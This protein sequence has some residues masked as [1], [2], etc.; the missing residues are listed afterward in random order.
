MLNRT[1]ESAKKYGDKVKKV[2]ASDTE[3]LIF[4]VFE[5]LEG[6]SSASDKYL[7]DGL[8]MSELGNRRVSEKL[9][10]FIKENL[11]ELLPTDEHLPYDEL[12]WRNML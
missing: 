9:V 7:N 12:V 11:S 6:G 8:H 1:N 4:D 10:E 2:L 3:T 5:A